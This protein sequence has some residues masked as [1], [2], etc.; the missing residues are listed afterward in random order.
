[1]AEKMV[2][3]K[4]IMEDV[5]HQANAALYG[6]EYYL[7]RMIDLAHSLDSF[8]DYCVKINPGYEKKFKGL[9]EIWGITTLLESTA[10]LCKEALENRREEER[11]WAESHK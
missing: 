8:K 1:M 7:D 4:D 3:G 10:D 2:E 5:Q 6:L 11:K 9:G